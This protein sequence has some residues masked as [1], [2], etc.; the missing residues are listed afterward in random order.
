ME[1]G[2]VLPIVVDEANRVVAGWAIVQA[3][4]KLNLDK[5]LAVTITD[6]SDAQLRALRLALNRIGE[7]VDCHWFDRQAPPI[8]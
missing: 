2:L 6:L 4:R 7:D 1:F 8:L 3:C 5:I